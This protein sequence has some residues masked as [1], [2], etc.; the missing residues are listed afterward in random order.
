MNLNINTTLDD[1]ISQLENLRKDTL[2]PQLENRIIELKL[3]KERN[4]L[5]QTAPFQLDM[6]NNAIQH[7]STIC[8][9]EEVMKRVGVIKGGGLDIYS[10][11]AEKLYSVYKA[12]KG[13]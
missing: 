12:H 1:F 11:I 6:K 2:N 10:Q 5:L 3:I 8:R 13:S 7:I 9:D 4:G